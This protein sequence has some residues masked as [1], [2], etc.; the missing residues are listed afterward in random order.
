MRFKNTDDIKVDVKD[1]W[2]YQSEPGATPR[3]A[4]YFKNNREKKVIT[5]TE[6]P[7]TEEEKAMEQAAQ[8]AEAT[9]AAVGAAATASVSSA[10]LGGAGSSVVY[11]IK[12]FNI[13]EIISNLAKLNVKFG[14]KI[15]IVMDFIE[16]L[17]LPQFGVIAQF[18]PLND[19]DIDSPDIDAYQLIPKGMRGK[20]TTN[21]QE[22]FIASGQNFFISCLIIGLFV[23]LTLLE[24]CL[25]K[26]NVILGWVSFLYQMLIGM[27]F[28]DYQ[29]IC[30][31]EVS[32][33]NYTNLRNIPPKYRVSLALSLLMVLLIIYEFYHAYK[34][35]RYNATK[36]IFER[37]TKDNIQIYP[38][39]KLILDKYTEA[40]KLDS[41]G[42]HT[43]LTL[44]EN[45]RFFIIQVIVASMQ[46]LNRTQALLV[47]IINLSYFI[48][49][50]KLIFTVDLFSS[51]LLMFKACVQEC[52]IMVAII[53]ISM[54]SFTESTS[55]SES[56]AYKGVE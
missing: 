40:I 45:L 56:T 22:V 5:I 11:L 8:A 46:L 39:D 30:A 3:I 35:I 6:K 36:I 17:K 23:L 31:S 27:M 2:I 47:L 18:S 51:K 44:L 7:E 12:F 1:P 32:I 53:T 28:F 29:L 52:C 34:M 48:F 24:C 41:Y 38:N 42:A 54:F 20:I 14:P 10:A 4:T 13:L 33:F 9:R 50:L 19:T 55:F 16:N 37:N 43:Y 15:L 49:F 21:N 25:D 26:K